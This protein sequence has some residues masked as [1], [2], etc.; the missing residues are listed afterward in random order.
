LSGTVITMNG[1][2][3]AAPQIARQVADG[4]QAMSTGAQ[5]GK[6]VRGKPKASGISTSGSVQLPVSKPNKARLGDFL[7]VPDA[8][9]QT[10]K[11]RYPANP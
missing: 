5:A 2:S 1:T 10:L 6:R 9:P 7:L 8:D 4:L 3:V 11:R